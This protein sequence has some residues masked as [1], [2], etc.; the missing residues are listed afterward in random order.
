M[1]NQQ[2]KLFEKSLKEERK[3]QFRKTLYWFALP[4][5]KETNSIDIVDLY[6]N[7][8]QF[9]NRWVKQLL[10]TTNPS[11]ELHPLEGEAKVLKEIYNEHRCNPLKKIG[12]G[13]P[14]LTMKDTTGQQPFIVAPMFIWT[15]NLD[16][17]S[18]DE[19]HWRIFRTPDLSLVPNE[20]V[21]QHLEKQ[22]IDIR[23]DFE[24]AIYNN[25][26]NSINLQ[27]LCNEISIKMDFETSVNTLSLKNFPSQNALQ[28]I[29]NGNGEIIW[30]GTVGLFEMLPTKYLKDEVATGT[31]GDVKKSSSRFNENFRKHNFSSAKFDPF[32]AN[33]LRGLT[34]NDRI[35]VEGS[36]YTG[37][38]DFVVGL[39]SNVLV[40]GGK[41]LVVSKHPEIL[42]KVQ[43]AI[44]EHLNMDTAAIA[45]DDLHLQKEIFYSYLRQVSEQSKKHLPFD[46]EEYQ[47]MLNVANRLQGKLDLM[48]DALNKPIF[49]GKIWIEL[50]GEFLENHGI[51]GRQL[52]NSQLLATDYDYKGDSYEHYKGIV[53]RGKELYA[54]VNTLR[55]PLEVLHEDVFTKNTKENAK[56]FTEAQIEKHSKLVSELYHAFVLQIEEY[57]QALQGLYEKHH[58]NLSYKAVEIQEYTADNHQRFGSDFN[59]WNVVKNSK[60]KFFGLFSE[61]YE[62]I[63]KSKKDLL[64]SFQELQN[65]YYNKRYFDYS[66]AEIKGSVTF[67]KVS[68]NL[69]DF[70]VSLRN[71]KQEFPVII[72]NEIQR[73]SSQTIHPDLD[74]KNQLT[75]LQDRLNQTLTNLNEANLYK[76]D[77]KTSESFVINNKVF[78]ERV[79]DN[80]EG[81]TFNLRDFD[82]YYEWRSFWLSLSEANQKL[83]KAFIT[84][85]P[86][87]WEKAYDSWFLHQVLLQHQNKSIPN[88]DNIFNQYFENQERLQTFIPKKIE[89]YW[90]HRRS[91]I[92]QTLKRVDKMGYNTYFA[93]RIPS[94]LFDVP[95][96]RMIASYRDTIL[97]IIPVLCTTPEIASN[98]LDKNSYETVIILEADNIVLEEGHHLMNLAKEAIICGSGR[99]KRKGKSE[100][101]MEFVKDNYSSYI[102]P[103]ETEH[104]QVY[105]DFVNRAYHRG[106]LRSGI[107]V[108][109]VDY[110]M[111]MKYVEGSYDEK[112]L[113]NDDE[114]NEVIRILRNFRSEDNRYLPK[115]GIV[116]FTIEHR[117]RLI[118]KLKNIQKQKLDGFKEI[119]Q[120][121]RN[122][123]TVCTLED[124]VGKEFDVVIISTTF[125]NSSNV[126]VS[127]NSLSTAQG[128][129]LIYHLLTASSTSMMICTSLSPEFIAENRFNYTNNGLSILCIL[130]DFIHA[131]Q[132]GDDNQ[133]S[134]ILAGLHAF[135]DEAATPEKM[136]V[137]EVTKTLK[138]QFGN[139]R[140][141]ESL[142][143]DL[144]KVDF[145]IKSVHENEP[146]IAAVVDS[147][148]W[149]F[150][151][152]DYYWDKL[153]R[154]SIKKQGFQF[155]AVW[156]VDWWKYPEKTPQQLV[157]Y[158]AIYDAEFEPVVEIPAE[159][160]EEIEDEEV[161]ETNEDLIENVAVI[162]TIEVESEDEIIEVTTDE[163]VNPITEEENIV[164]EI[165]ENLEAL[166]TQNDDL[167]ETVNDAIS[168]E[169]IEEFVTETV[170]ET[171]EEKN[172]I[173]ESTIEN[174]VDMINDVVKTTKKTSF[175][176]RIS[177]VFSSTDSKSSIETL[178]KIENSELLTENIEES[179]DVK[180]ST[181]NMENHDG[182][183]FPNREV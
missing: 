17:I 40:N 156:S 6:P 1:S 178:E 38:Y 114:I 58:D 113:Y 148:F 63:L 167:I 180:D 157:D 46:E 110:Q 32:Q 140:V 59:N 47:L 173:I 183:I 12:F 175:F 66:F 7:D 141:Q 131:N 19:N 37:M 105:S 55:H 81:L 146:P 56:K 168:E 21:I 102:L 96:D 119:A 23:A 88:S 79:M 30:S 161:I 74:Y 159:I 43:N 145:W 35:A 25:Q 71:W 31:E 41:T 171:D 135:Y 127:F 52:L 142:F 109:P 152:G 166:E 154:E 9:P 27:K 33:I 28:K 64:A 50:I 108:T 49:K 99:L 67:E 4:S 134:T 151:K 169:I 158:V 98:Y 54:K 51:E 73:L 162:E 93:K 18:Y 143:F 69:E 14:M 76:N 117:N 130:I 44:N 45:L 42:Q 164:E 123:L 112:T 129:Y 139:D 111:S 107:D 182:V 106:R 163:I 39:I 125:S 62:N 34:D 92:L 3:N 29:S 22:G 122:G 104:K 101:L 165:V 179:K 80:L 138:H 94:G 128:E 97:D 155:H 65:T 153:L 2:S 95:L 133:I 24:V 89:N 87:S 124:I 36:V 176:S 91:S 116:C 90:T 82:E 77:Y 170:E 5:K 13:Y 84:T 48:H 118:E 174:D 15:V 149:Q 53:L 126:K 72:H 103:F 150:P 137:N 26:I 16:A 57:G 181:E 78:L 85:K 75:D 8:N 144:A 177:N 115:V 10:D 121:F 83:L 20:L 86:D 11:A 70:K 120:F 60:L 100:T 136:M 147:F 61:R 160:T 68:E 132:N 172:S